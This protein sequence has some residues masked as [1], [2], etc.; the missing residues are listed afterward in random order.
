MGRLMR[1]IANAHATLPPYDS[2]Q[3]IID[4]ERFPA[5]IPWVAVSVER[6]GRSYSCSQ[7][8]MASAPLGQIGCLPGRPHFVRWLRPPRCDVD[9]YPTD[10]GGRVDL[11]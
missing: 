4:P 1:S 6:D 9:D 7:L 8:A 11:L 10:Y 5:Q 2:N 3:V